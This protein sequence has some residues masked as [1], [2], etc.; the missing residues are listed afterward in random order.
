MHELKELL[1][2]KTIAVFDLDG[3]IANTEPLHWFTHKKVFKTLGINLTEENIRRYVGHNDLQIF[4]MIEEDYN[5]LLEDKEELKQKR[6]QLFRQAVEKYNL[7]PNEEVIY[8]IKNF[9]GKRYIVSRQNQ[10]TIERLLENWKILEYFDKIYSL[11]HTNES[12]TKFV[13][14]LGNKSE[15]V[16]FEDS[17]EV[18]KEAKDE[19]F[20]II[21]VRHSY[22]EIANLDADYI[23]DI[24]KPRK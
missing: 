14:T 1:K 13:E 21:V 18:V 22:N 17:T 15:I 5:V 16:W 11:E 2:G 4:G 3:T 12:K 23:I 9:K 7:L 20:T 19:G 8:A 6:L 24:T 10:Y